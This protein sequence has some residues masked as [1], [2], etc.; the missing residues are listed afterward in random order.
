MHQHLKKSQFALISVYQTVENTHHGPTSI[1]SQQ[2]A[3]LMNEGRVVSPRQAFQQDLITT[4]KILQ[5]N[6]IEVIIAGDFNTALI[7][8]GV[9]QGLCLQCNLELVNNTDSIGSTYQQ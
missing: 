9:I 1:Y 7:S 2:V 4:I 6:K 3:I 8:E 5:V